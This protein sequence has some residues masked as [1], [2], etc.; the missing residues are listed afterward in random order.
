MCRSIENDFR[1]PQLVPKTRIDFRCGAVTRLTCSR[2]PVSSK[3]PR[4]IKEERVDKNTTQHTG[5]R[6]STRRGSHSPQ[7]THRGRAQCTGRL[8]AQTRTADALLEFETCPPVVPLCES[9]RVHVSKGL[10]S[11]KDTVQLKENTKTRHE[12]AWANSCQNTMQKMRN[13]GMIQ[14]A[15]RFVTSHS[16]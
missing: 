15:R 3:G 5:T 1:R 11:C 16:P 4:V 10:N 13:K 8:R 12:P 2:K 6:S 7:Y 9:D 14:R